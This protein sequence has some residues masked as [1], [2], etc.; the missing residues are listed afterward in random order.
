MVVNGESESGEERS[1]TGREKDF[2][3][4]FL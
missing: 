2:L 4:L 1:V 3:F